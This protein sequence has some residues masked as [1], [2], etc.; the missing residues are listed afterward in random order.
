ML[1]GEGKVWSA[2]TCL[3]TAKK[4]KWV[5]L[6]LRGSESKTEGQCDLN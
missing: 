6:G 2:G 5:S 1:D 3:G 4:G